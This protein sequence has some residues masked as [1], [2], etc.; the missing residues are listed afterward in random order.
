MLGAVATA[1]ARVSQRFLPKPHL[2]TLIDLVAGEAGYGV[3][4]SHSGTVVAALPPAECTLATAA[5]LT[6]AT[7][8]LGMR[9]VSQYSLAAPA[10]W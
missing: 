6:K 9:V 5:R 3:C 2:E 7:T 4:V 1:S 8:R 10:G